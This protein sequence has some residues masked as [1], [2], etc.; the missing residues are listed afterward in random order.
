MTRAVPIPESHTKISLHGGLERPEDTGQET[1][2]QIKELLRVTYARQTWCCLLQKERTK[3][4]PQ[5]RAGPFQ[6]VPTWDRASTLAYSKGQR[7]PKLPPRNSCISLLLKS[8]EKMRACFCFYTY[9]R[10]YNCCAFNSNLN[11]AQAFEGMQGK[12]ALKSIPI[13]QKFFA[14]ALVLYKPLRVTNTN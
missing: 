6:Q 11:S 9:L 8:S 4:E 3:T 10:K 12:M 7:V 2:D 13:S 1:A 14:S 5:A